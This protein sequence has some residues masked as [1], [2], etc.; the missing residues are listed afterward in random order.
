MEA[1]GEAAKTGAFTLG[2]CLTALRA[3]TAI[4]LR[5]YAGTQGM[6][7]AS[8]GRAITRALRPEGNLNDE[9]RSRLADIAERT[10]VTLL[11]KAGARI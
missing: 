8:G 6:V 5:M 7:A 4:T 3:C 10:P 2:A 11:L 9:Q 1:S